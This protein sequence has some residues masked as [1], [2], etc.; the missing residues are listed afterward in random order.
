LDAPYEQ[1]YVSIVFPATCSD[2]SRVVRKIQFPH[3]ESEHEHE[4]LRIWNGSGAVRLLDHDADH[5]A[6]LL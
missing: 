4:A 2:G 1:S 5:H 3:D 6:L